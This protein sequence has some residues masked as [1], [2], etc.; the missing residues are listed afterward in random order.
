MPSLVILYPDPITIHRECDGQ[1]Y[2]MPT[3]TAIKVGRYLAGQQCTVF[4]MQG[5]WPGQASLVMLGLTIT[6]R[7]GLNRSFYSLQYQ[8][9]HQ[10]PTILLPTA[11]PAANTS[12]I[13]IGQWLSMSTY[14][15]WL[16]LIWAST[17][18]AHVSSRL[19][20]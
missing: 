2:R 20:A 10:P 8:L 18:S 7:G 19:M 4:G 16:R 1:P 9:H 13:H 11:K 15:V 6:Q 14:L 5:E 17:W 12:T 3:T